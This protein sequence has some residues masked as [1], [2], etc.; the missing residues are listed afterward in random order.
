MRQ[1]QFASHYVFYVL[2]LSC[3]GAAC[4]ALDHRALYMSNVGARYSFVLSQQSSPI[5]TK[6]IKMGGHPRER[7]AVISMRFLTAP[8]YRRR[9]QAGLLGDEG[10]LCVPLKLVL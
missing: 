7:Y 10:M 4:L 1:Y 6:E 8:C 9:P 2:S 3:T 5:Q